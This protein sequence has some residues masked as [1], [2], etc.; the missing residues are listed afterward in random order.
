MNIKVLFLTCLGLLVSVVA[1]AQL[2]VENTL[3]V[4][5]LVNQ[6]LLGEG[7][8]ATNI[9]YNGMPGDSVHVQVG[10]FNSE[11]SNIPISEGLIMASGA[12]DVA[13]GP[14]DLGGATENTGF[15]SFQNDPDLEALISPN[16][17]AD[18]AIVEFDFV[19]NADSLRFNY[20]FASEEYD[21]Y[22]C[23]SFNDAFGFFL[24]GPGINGPYSNNAENI[25]IVPG[26]DIP[27]A[28]NTVNLGVVGSSGTLSNCEDFHPDWDQNSEYYTSYSGDTTPE[29]SQ[30]DGMTVSLTALADIECGAQYHIKIAIGDGG[31]ASFTDTAFDSAVFLEAGSFAAFGEVFVNVEP[32]IGGVTVSDPQYADVVVAGCSDFGVELTRPEGLPVDSVFVQFGGTAI[33]GQDYILGENDTLFFFPDGV[34]TLNFSIE[35]L[36]DGIPGE[37]EELIFMVIFPNGCDEYDTAFATI[38]MVDPY[39]LDLA[40]SDDEVL[41]CIGETA[42]LE[43]EGSNGITPYTYNWSWVDNDGNIQTATGPSY[44]VVIPPNDATY[45]TVSVTDP[46][47]FQPFTMDSILVTNEIPEPLEGNIVDFSQPTCPNEPILFEA[48][49]MNGTPP[50]YYIWEKN[51]AVEGNDETFEDVDFFDHSINLRVT[52]DCGEIVRDTVDVVYPAFEPMVA[53]MEPLEDN[54]PEGP[55]ALQAFSTG[56]AGE[57]EYT[58]SQTAGI[59]EFVLPPV[60]ESSSVLLEGGLN[61]IQ[62]QATDR[63]HRLGL[64]NP[65]VPGQATGTDTLLVISIDKLQNILTPNGDGKNDVF[66]IEGAQAFDAAQLIVYDRWG[67]IVYETDNYEVGSPDPALTYDNPFDGKDLEDGTYFYVISIDNGDCTESGSL[68]IISTDN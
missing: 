45:Y 57:T 3:T 50:Y 49:A 15:T 61:V 30:F 25:A 53:W 67:T 21:E 31:S 14:N 68:E 36:W 27:V 35:T 22:V 63:C 44:N 16:T 37:N 42:L 26:T 11:S 62:I 48:N 41:E 4:T 54:C 2:V 33:E 55:V 43:A 60:S 20:V 64:I 13:V 28:I 40:V 66:V 12:I 6:I 51:F 7:V 47:G 59:G 32:N 56:G 52:D 10:T 58:W 24:S 29:Y 18:C 65:L 8:T 5:E 39:V 34:D 19:A 23:S 1:H 17:I 9:T 46:C 38:P